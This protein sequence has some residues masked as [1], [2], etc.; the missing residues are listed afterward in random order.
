MKANEAVEKGEVEPSQN[1][2]HTRLLALGKK[3]QP[4]HTRTTIFP[5]ASTGD[6]QP[7]KPRRRPPLP[8]M[9]VQ[10]TC[11]SLRPYLDGQNIVSLDC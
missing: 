5:Y 7:P 6:R 9:Y 10:Y 1:T 11:T 4:T 8:Q 2:Q 3:H